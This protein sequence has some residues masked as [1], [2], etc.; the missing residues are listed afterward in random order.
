[1]PLASQS[2]PKKKNLKKDQ[3]PKP[4]PP[5]SAPS[6]YLRLAIAGVLGLVFLSGIFFSAAQFK[7]LVTEIEEKRGQ[8]VA[9]RQKEENLKLLSTSLA[10]VKPEAMLIEKALPNEREIID[11][12]K[13]TEDL[14]KEVAINS[15]S[16]ESDRPQLDL[17]G[18]GFIEWTI[19]AIGPLD[20][21]EKFL[22]ELLGLPIL[23]QPKI[24]DLDKMD[25]EESKLVF[26]AR[27]F[28][29]PDFF[30]REGNQ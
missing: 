29:A 26:R 17:A 3:K 9:L 27:L 5:F 14:G 4:R 7:K 18:N 19:E 24:I 8:M 20:K 10:S 6:L 21:L 1:M 30:G 11:F 22:N 12:I 15:F 28:V 23:I 13:K 25:Q 16:F 2:P